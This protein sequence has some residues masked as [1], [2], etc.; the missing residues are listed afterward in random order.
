MAGPGRT[1]E[2]NRIYQ[3]EW[4][5]NNPERHASWRKQYERNNRE[6]A[7]Q[8][9]RERRLRVPGLVKQQNIKCKYGLTPEQ[10]AEMVSSQE[11][12]C[13]ICASPPL[14]NK[15]LYV[16]HDHATGKVRQLLC[17]KCNWTIGV[18]ETNYHDLPAYFSY[19]ETHGAIQ[20]T[21]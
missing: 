20:T 8:R 17:A 6:R 13:A 3:A 1:K 12:V 14:G 4:R 11:G 9:Q 5:A 19:L 16:D 7:N 15:P 2:Q 10:Q 21:H 18:L